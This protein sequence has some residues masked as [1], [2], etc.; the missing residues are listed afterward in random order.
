ML[1]LFTEFIRI[2]FTFCVHWG[3]RIY[4]YSLY[5]Y[6]YSLRILIRVLRPYIMFS[7]RLTIYFEHYI[8]R[9]SYLIIRFVIRFLILVLRAPHNL[10]L[11]SRALLFVFLVLVVGGAALA[12]CSSTL[13]AIPGHNSHSEI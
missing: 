2:A 6:Y 12:S 7:A 4:Y 11:A 3:V 5:A 13:P 8:I 9:L 10:L 1:L